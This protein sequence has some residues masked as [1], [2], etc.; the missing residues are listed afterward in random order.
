MEKMVEI[1]WDA[2]NNRMGISKG[3]RL[4]MIFF[5][6]IIFVIHR[7]RIITLIPKVTHNLLNSKSSNVLGCKTSGVR[8]TIA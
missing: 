6:K 4:K 5:A 2:R 8:N 3:V 7:K 1:I